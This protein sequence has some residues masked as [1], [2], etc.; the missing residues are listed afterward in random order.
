MSEK[1]FHNQKIVFY[2]Q[3][4]A[5]TLPV[6]GAQPLGDG[7][8][9]V[10][11]LTGE[12]VLLAGGQLRPAHLDDEE[13]NVEREPAEGE[14]EDQGDE[15]LE[16]LH[17]AALDHQRGL[18]VA[19]L[20]RGGQLAGQLGQL[21]LGDL[22]QDE[23]VEEGNHREGNEV[24]QAQVDHQKVRLLHLRGGPDVAAYLRAQGKGERKMLLIKTRIVMLNLE[25][26]TEAK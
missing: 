7:D 23:N 25:R 24:L 18:A 15:H 13:E 19:V 10:E 22:L 9:G 20:Q 4:I 6:G 8:G 1:V 5:S 3:K 21:P 2:R 17:L 26:L 16:D 12:G 11:D 14:E